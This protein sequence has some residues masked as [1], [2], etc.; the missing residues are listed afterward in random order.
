MRE[1]IYLD[2][3]DTH[4]GIVD[5]LDAVTHSHDQ[6]AL[7]AHTVDKFHRMLSDVVSLA[8]L[9][10]GSVQRSTKSIT[11]KTSNI[12][13]VVCFYLHLLAKRLT[14]VKRPDTKEDTK[15]LP[16]LAQTMVL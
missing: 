3:G 16:A 2:D 4:V 6:L 15:S 7:L 12:E 5:A 9:T 14:M 8:E 10:S 1:S 13:S 11:L